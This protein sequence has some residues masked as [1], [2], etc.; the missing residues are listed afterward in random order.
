M[1]MV[2]F[3]GRGGRDRSADL[4]RRR[5]LCRDCQSGDGGLSRCPRGREGFV[6]RGWMLLD[7]GRGY[8]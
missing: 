8:V 7:G 2:M 5:G 1:L 3:G 4:A 6:G